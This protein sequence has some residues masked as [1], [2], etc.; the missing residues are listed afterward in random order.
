M[1]QTLTDNEPEE[2]N[3][4]GKGERVREKEIKYDTHYSR[5]EVKVSARH[6]TQQART[7]SLQPCST[8]L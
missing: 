1:P 3:S 7:L 6:C 8:I 5:D 2:G 4:D